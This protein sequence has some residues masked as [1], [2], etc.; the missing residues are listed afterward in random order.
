MIALRPRRVLRHTRD[1]GQALPQNAAHQ[2][3]SSHAFAVHSANAIYSVIPKNACTTLRYSIAIANGF[4]RPGDPFSWVNSNHLS[5]RATLSEIIRAD[6]TFIVLRDPFLRLVSCYFDKISAVMKVAL[7]FHEAVNIDREPDMVTFRDFVGGLRSALRADPHWRPQVDF[8][9]YDRYDDY[10]AF[11]DFS[12]IVDTLG[13]R[14]GLVIHDT[15]NLRRHATE[16]YVSD[17][18]N[19]SFADMPAYEIGDLKRAGRLPRHEQLYDAAL[20]AQVRAL[21]REDI[22]LYSEATGRHCHW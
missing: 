3:A 22:A 14:I 9:T 11:E 10:F 12:K 5:Q 2:F 4:I 18:S 19:E 6:Y 15:R 16:R 17:M 20:V 13:A 21:Y 8:L 1:N 7:A